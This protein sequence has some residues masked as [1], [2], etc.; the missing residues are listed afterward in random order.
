MASKL[1]NMPFNVHR[2]IYTLELAPGRF[3]EPYTTAYINTNLKKKKCLKWLLVLIN[4]K[5]TE[6]FFREIL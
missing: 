4:L 6:S 5:Y 1:Q 3:H 2:Q